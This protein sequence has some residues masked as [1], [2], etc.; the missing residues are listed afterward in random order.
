MP[1]ALAVVGGPEEE[2][3]SLGEWAQDGKPNS[4]PGPAAL[5]TA[6]PT[7]LPSPRSPEGEALLIDPRLDGV[8]A[9]LAAYWAGKRG[10][11]TP[12]AFAA[13][14]AQL[15]QILQSPIGGIEA[16]RE[17]LQTAAMKDWDFI[18]HQTWQAWR[19][20]CPEP[21][22]LS[23]T[24]L[25]AGADEGSALPGFKAFH[26]RF[27]ATYG[28]QTT[29]SDALRAYENSRARLSYEVSLRD[30]GSA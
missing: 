27:K 8:A 3:G 25:F 13:Q 5:P 2:E 1:P 18:R 12:L 19:S 23:E 10:A 29:L 17:Q 7:A 30:I 6:P 9:E 16:V 20:R 15:I 14:Q 4:R 21:L 28:P 24:E 22:Q 26:R 11:R